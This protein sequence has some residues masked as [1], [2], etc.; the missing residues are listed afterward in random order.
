MKRDPSWYVADRRFF[1]RH[2]DRQ[3]RLRK[4]HSHELKDW[5]EDLPPQEDGKMWATVVDCTRQP[6]GQFR[7][8]KLVQLPEP[9]VKHAHA[10]DDFHLDQMFVTGA[11]IF[12]ERVAHIMPKGDAG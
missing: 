6:T 10:F 5:P 4:T 3:F 7:R 9:F 11:I 8:R 1:D 2:P 12:D